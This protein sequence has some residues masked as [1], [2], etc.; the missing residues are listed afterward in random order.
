MET[1][2][3]QLTAYEG[4][5]MHTH[6]DPNN[7]F[8]KIWRFDQTVIFELLNYQINYDRTIWTVG[9]KIPFQSQYIW[10]FKQKDNVALNSEQ[11]GNILVTIA[12]TPGKLPLCETCKYYVGSRYLKCA[13]NPVDCSVELKECKDYVAISNN[14][15]KQCPS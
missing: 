13:V 3:I 8:N 4:A 1:R 7:P 5:I 11:H 15:N 12:Y 14:D 10:Y 2:S 6:L 9:F